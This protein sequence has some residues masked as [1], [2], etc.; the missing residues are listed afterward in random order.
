MNFQD[1][2][3]C[4]WYRQETEGTPYFIYLPCLGCL[5]WFKSKSKVFW[6]CNQ[7]SAKNYLE[8][9]YLRGLAIKYFELEKKRKNTIKELFL[10]WD[11]A[12]RVK[13]EGIFKEVDSIDLNKISDKKLLSL[14]K[15]LAYQTFLMWKKFFMDIF[16]VDA[17]GLIE[18]G[19][20]LFLRML[21]LP[22]WIQRI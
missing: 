21:I 13:D 18:T 6:F 8:K 2:E 22:V 1:I 16:D 20:L 14:N 4:S 17:E 12:I 15:K 10:D 7:Y 11:R 5:T 19:L 3:K 9:E